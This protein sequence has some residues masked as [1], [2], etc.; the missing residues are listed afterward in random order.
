MKLLNVV[1]MILIYIKMC[2]NS[3]V[4][5]KL[6]VTIQSV[7]VNKTSKYFKMLKSEFSQ[8]LYSCEFYIPE[9]LYSIYVDKK[10]FFF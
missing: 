10:D 7:Y 6:D 2:E 8:G 3:M 1:L 4:D 5:A 9:N